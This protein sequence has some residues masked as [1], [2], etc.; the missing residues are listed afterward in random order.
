MMVFPL[1]FVDIV[2]M[3]MPVWVG[4]ILSWNW[5]GLVAES[6]DDTEVCI[7]V[8]FNMIHN[9]PNKGLKQL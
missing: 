3:W 7:Y 9:E 4:G 8:H 1:V 2:E 5:R 6:L